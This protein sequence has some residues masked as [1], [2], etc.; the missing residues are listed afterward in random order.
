M[1]RRRQ[2]TGPAGGLPRARSVTHNDGV[3]IPRTVGIL[4]RGHVMKVELKY[5]SV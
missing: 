3:R 1:T 2:L 5:C 4:T